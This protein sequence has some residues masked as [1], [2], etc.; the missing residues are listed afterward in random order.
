MAASPGTVVLIHGLWMT[1]RSFENFQR[2]YEARGLHVLVP[3][4]PRMQGEVEEIRSDPSPLDGLGIKEIADHYDDLLRGM[5][6]QPILMG[7]SFGGLIVQ[8]LLDRGLGAAGVAID[9]A[10]PKG[11]LRL[12]LTQLRAASPALRNPANRNRTVAL[13][14]P[15][16]Q[17]AFVNTLTDADA[18]A[19]YERYPI[20]GPARPL[21]EGAAANLN[22]RAPS[23]VDY[24][25]ADRAPLL[26]IAGGEDHTVPPSVVRDNFGK[27][28]HSKAMTG[29]REFPGRAHLQMVQDGWE[30][31]AEYAIDWAQD[32]VSARATHAGEIAASGG[33]PASESA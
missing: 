2:L 22:P 26:L 15:Q 24:R 14:F 30:A 27:Y 25:N 17:Y 5:G 11:I 23:K 9:A 8:L 31:V 19:A 3:P 28:R 32:Q 12:P 6:E 21:F 18:R 4:W 1:P 20:P 13:T 33:A 16:F 29:F 7:H 10:A